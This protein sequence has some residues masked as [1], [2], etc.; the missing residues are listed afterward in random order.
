MAFFNGGRTRRA[1][2]AQWQLFRVIGGDGVQIPM[3]TDFGPEVVSDTLET[4]ATAP[5]VPVTTDSMSG[6]GAGSTPSGIEPPT[7][8][9]PQG[10]ER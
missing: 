5:T 1:R 2:A 3:D 10:R 8:G 4:P 9:G 7:P 6:S